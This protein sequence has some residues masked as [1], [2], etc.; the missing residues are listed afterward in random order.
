MDPIGDINQP[1]RL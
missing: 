1:H